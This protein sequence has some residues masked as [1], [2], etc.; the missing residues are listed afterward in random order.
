MFM[1]VLVIVSFGFKNCLCSVKNAKHLLLSI[2]KALPKSSS[3]KSSNPAFEYILMH[4]YLQ[5][6][7][8]TH[9]CYT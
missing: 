5:A 4:S 1:A 3:S 2:A 7:V 6:P 8:A 9:M